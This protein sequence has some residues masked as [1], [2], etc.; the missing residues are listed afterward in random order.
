[1]HGADRARLRRC[2]SRSANLRGVKESGALFAGPTFVFV[3]LLGFMI[4]VGLF[5]RFIDGADAIAVPLASEAVEAVQTLTLFLLL[6]GVRLGLHGDDRRRGDR[7]RRPGVQGA[8]GEER[9]PRRSRGW[10]A[11][12]SFLFLG[13][14]CARRA[15][16]RAADVETETVISQISRA[17]L[18]HR[19]RSTT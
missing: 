7:Q 2:C 11:S 9:A 8:G 1:M 12:C 16:R 5:V 13:I 17:A 15:R 19:A 6:Q 18:R 3:V 4:V 10:P 14:S